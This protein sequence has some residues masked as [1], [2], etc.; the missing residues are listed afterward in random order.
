MP[1]ILTSKRFNQALARKHRNLIPRVMDQLTKLL[2]AP[3]LPGLNFERLTNIDGLYSIRITDNY[4]ALLSLIQSNG[5][6]AYFF[7]DIGPHDIYRILRNQSGE[8]QFSDRDV[9]VAKLINIKREQN[10]NS[11]PDSPAPLSRYIYDLT[12]VF[13]DQSPDTVDEEFFDAAIDRFLETTDDQGFI[14]NAYRQGALFV[15][16]S[17]G[18]GK[19]TA[20]IFRAMT[21]AELAESVLL[22]TYN[23]NL[24]QVIEYYTERLSL[25][26]SGGQLRAM[27]FEELVQWIL[28][29]TGYP[30]IQAA[31]KKS[32]SVELVRDILRKQGIRERAIEIFELIYSLK[33]GRKFDHRR[34]CI[35][36]HLD[37]E[38]RQ[39]I[40]HRWEAENKL[41]VSAAAFE[42]IY[43][44]YETALKHQQYRRRPT[45]DTADVMWDLYRHLQET[46]PAF[47]EFCLIIDEVQDFRPLEFEVI[48]LM[49][50]SM[51]EQDHWEDNRLSI[52]GDI[53]QQI[54]LTDFTWERMERDYRATTHIL[55]RNHRNT[56][57][58][59]D[60]DQY[61]YNL[62]ISDDD[63]HPW[64]PPVA[65]GPR[66]L[67]IIGEEEVWLDWLTAFLKNNQVPQTLGILVE[68]PET[69]QRLESRLDEE[70]DY[71]IAPSEYC[72]GLE[73]EDLILIRLFSSYRPH[74]GTGRHIQKKYRD[75]WHVSLSRARTNLLLFLTQAEHEHVQSRIM[76]DQAEEFF[77]GFDIVRSTEEWDEAG[78]QFLELC[79]FDP[80]GI[81]DILLRM[82]QGDFYWERYLESGHEADKF[83]ALRRYEYTRAFDKARERLESLGYDR[84]DPFVFLDAAYLSLQANQPDEFRTGL[85]RYNRAQRGMKRTEKFRHLL[86]YYTGTRYYQQHCA[87]IFDGIVKVNVYPYRFLLK[88][89]RKSVSPEYREA[90]HCIALHVLIEN[91]KTI[92]QG[93]KEL[94]HAEK[95]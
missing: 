53:H 17:A 25:E 7:H 55:N 41:P 12:P 3:D 39:Q 4:R 77:A 40:L 73:F 67:L 87:R 47:T 94:R 15:Q 32:Q 86:E 50:E 26:E 33:T 24:K 78:R 16:G 90:L 89:L 38:E 65:R 84:N 43:Q 64:L 48:R 13:T 37:P 61:L 62:C 49:L 5:N 56:V 23:E 88:T 60:V 45:R 10:P 42:D 2:R 44:A 75:L 6:R 72:K 34:E 93:I 46:Q 70:D 29:Q 18:T 79:D 63:D 58:I 51:P 69:L 21:L 19:T 14:I 30:G 52:F 31:L 83:K 36:E 68:D 54:T 95:H 9:G 8:F 85:Q 1:K 81:A 80:P 92:L 82:G 74:Y 76:P 11:A 28:E 71:F 27:I 91:N 20:A 66:P 35:P 22:L 59:A 57:Q